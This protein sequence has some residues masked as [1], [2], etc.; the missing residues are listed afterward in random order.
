MKCIFGT[1]WITDF[2]FWLAGYN[3][4]V[5]APDKELSQY[6]RKFWTDEKPDFCVTLTEEAVQ[7]EKKTGNFPEGINRI[8]LEFL[9]LH[10][11]VCKELLKR[12]VLMLHGSAVDVDRECYV[13]VAPSG[14][15]KSTHTALW[16]RV[17]GEHGHAV[18]MINDDKPF[19]TVENGV[20][21]AH[22]SP[23]NGG[24]RGAERK[25]SIVRAV[26]ALERAEKNSI[27]RISAK[28]LT[29]VLFG[30]IFKGDS[31]EELIKSLSLLEKLVAGVSGYRLFCNT[32]ADAAELAYNYMKNENKSEEK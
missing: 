9:A 23:W 22:A 13:F 24:Y 30:S 4:G 31:T 17:L 16:R 25:K 12:D 20:V 2:V 11:A 32:D 7:K 3:V 6:C 18:R 8:Y 21:Y 1:V 27:S 14:T 26:C 5:T 19:I 10:R 15:G 29:P 28:E